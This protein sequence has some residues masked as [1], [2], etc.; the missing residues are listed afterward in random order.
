MA[1]YRPKGKKLVYVPEDLL[2]AV[3][4]IS[5]RKGESISKYVEDTLRQSVRTDQM[6]YSPE[7]VA[8]IIEMVHVQKVLGGTMLPI[9]I[10][11]LFFNER[12]NRDEALLSRWFESGK[13]Y[14]RYIKERFDDPVR[15][16]AML[17][18]TTRW[19][20]NEVGIKKL[21]DGY[22]LR[23]ISTSLS[24]LETAIMGRFIEGILSGLQCEIREKDL[25]RG[26]IRVHFTA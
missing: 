23:C 16:L 14:G 11:N 26:F 6:G 21:E 25:M 12:N 4:E 2:D 15:A 18:R 13:K 10:M 7:E 5:K 22:S 20:L 24:D 17:L 19:D 8:N 3:A 9:E 1:M